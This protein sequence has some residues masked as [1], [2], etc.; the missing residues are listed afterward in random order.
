VRSFLSGGHLPVGGTP[1][2]IRAYSRWLIRP[3]DGRKPMTRTS[4]S[5]RYLMS[6]VSDG[7]KEVRV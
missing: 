6:P 2:G 1:R 5:N 3:S 4:S 7:L